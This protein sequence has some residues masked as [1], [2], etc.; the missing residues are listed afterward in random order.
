MKK[1]LKWLLG[2]VVVLFIVAG[3]GIVY[4]KTALPDVGKAPALKVEATPER[5]AR[6]RYLANSVTVCMDCHSKRDWSRYSGP[7]V[8]GTEGQG[9][10]VFDR[11]LGFPGVYYSKNITP[12]GIG[13]WTDGELYRAIT[14]GVSKSG[15]PLFPVM[16]YHYYGNM[17]DEDIYSIIAYIRSLPV[18]KNDIPEREI[19]FPLNIILNTIPRKGRPAIIPERSDTLAYGGYLVNAA[20][21]MECH[22][23]AEKGQII[24]EFAFAGGREFD[25][26]WGIIRTPNITPDETGLGYWSRE[27]FVQTF[28]QYQ[29]SAYHS[30]VLKGSDFNTIMP[31]TMYGRMTES[32][33]LSIYAFLK[34]VKPI[35]NEV[36]RFTPKA[37]TVAQK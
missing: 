19:D 15:S 11:K 33:L 27:K 2:I 4:I 18:I 12:Y 25:M 5:I 16:P 29:D 9:G 32:D 28:R 23:R 20:G 36:V 10:E 13:N 1:V 22:T 37:T 7:L 35:R 14:C 8:S 17:A 31:W 24:P 30:P 21:C 26:P 6:G 3:A 34:T